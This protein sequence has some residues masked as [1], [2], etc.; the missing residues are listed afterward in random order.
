MSK[1]MKFWLTTLV[2]ALGGGVFGFFAA[3]LSDGKETEGWFTFK[4]YFAF[5]YDTVFYLMAVTCLVLLVLVLSGL[6]KL[7]KYSHDVADDELYS[8][9]EKAVSRLFMQATLLQSIATVWMFAG[10]AY[11][12]KLS[13]SH[14]RI[15]GVLLI[16]SVVLTAVGWLFSRKV[17]KK[18]NEIVPRLSID[19]YDT[20]PQGQ[21]NHL[22]QRL[23]ESEKLQ[24]Y[25]A[26]FL[27]M[28]W[29]LTLLYGLLFVILIYSMIVESQINLLLLVGLLAIVNQS[30]YFIAT[31]QQVKKQGGA[32]Q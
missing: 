31:N 25:K 28:R 21:Y 32:A 5:P 30:F 7:K 18:M 10:A 8:P 1:K 4:W 29:M 2:L 24:M 12:F 15:V 17:M 23:D 14:E 3:H 9:A 27:A 20:D 26:G 6:Q 19:L 13:G 16:S 11:T 22:V